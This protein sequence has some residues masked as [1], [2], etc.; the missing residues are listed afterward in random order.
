[1]WSI[2]EDANLWCLFYSLF[3]SVLTLEIRLSRYQG[4]DPIHWFTPR[5]TRSASGTC[6]S[7]LLV[8]DLSSLFVYF[9]DI[10]GIVDHHWLNCLFII[11]FLTHFGLNDW[12]LLDVK[13]A[14]LHLIHGQNKLM[15]KYC[16]YKGDTSMCQW[17]VVWLTHVFDR[18][19]NLA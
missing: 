7:L 12:L 13:L 1:M 6:H 4:W 15:N 8:K 5:K 2:W 11:I 18:V 14:V 9:V 19:S 3:I 17:P 10:V 16:E